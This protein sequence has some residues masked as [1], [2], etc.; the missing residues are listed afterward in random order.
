MCLRHTPEFVLV[1]FDDYNFDVGF[2]FGV[3]A[4]VTDALRTV[5]T[6]QV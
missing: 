5:Q 4:L 6:V 3:V 1:R 2:G